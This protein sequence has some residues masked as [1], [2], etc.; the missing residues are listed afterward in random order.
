MG[1]KL[2]SAEDEKQAAAAGL[3]Q[4][5]MVAAEVEKALKDF[6]ID[7]ES[8]S[9]N[10]IHSLSDGQMFRVVLT[11][12][13]WLCPHILILDEPTNY[14]DRD[15]IGALVSGL[16]SFEGGVVVISH[17]AE[18]A[19][20]VC[21]EQKW[22]MQQGRLTEEGCDIEAKVKEEEKK[23]AEAEGGVDMGKMPDEITTA[24]GETIKIAKEITKKLKE[25]KKKKTLSDAERWE[26][27]DLLA[28]H[29][30]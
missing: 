9:H 8:A 15:G 24:N 22:V 7:A 30:T 23:K 5:P 26:L 11:A 10:P 21:P 20:T 12:A 3:L 18:F 2:A 17:D 1:E 4:R 19:S 13:M 27:E 29:E 25:D 16:E 28:Q 14:L 6:G